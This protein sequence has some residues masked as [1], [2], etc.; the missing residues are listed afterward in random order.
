MPGI[1]I[2]HAARDK[3][4]A[5]AFVDNI[6]RLGSGA[7][8]EQVFYSSGPDTGVPTGSNLNE[9]LREKVTNVGLV[10]ALITPTFKDRPFCIAELSVAW[11]RVGSLFP[12]TMPGT[13]P[14]DLDG[15]LSGLLVRSMTD[16]AALDE[17]HDRICRE[18][19]AD[20]EAATWGHYK[21]TWL[22]SSK[23]LVKKIAKPTKTKS[24]P[25]RKSKPSKNEL[26]VHH[27]GQLFD[28]FVDAALYTADDTVG[29]EEIEKAIDRRTLIPSR[30]LYSSDSGADNWVRL[31]RDPM[32]RHH[33]ESVDYW[34]GNAGKKMAALIKDRLGREDFDYISLGS[35]DGEKDADLIATW[36]K[37]GSDLLYYPY[38]ISLPLVSRAIRTVVKKAPASAKKERLHIKSVLADFH[39]IGTVSEVFKHRNSPNVVALLGN[40]LGNLEHDLG[41]LRDLRG[42]LSVDDLLVLE[43]RLKSTEKKEKRLPELASS[44]SL[45]FDFGPLEYYFGLTFNEKKMSTTVDGEVSSFPNT[46]TT[47]VSCTGV[48]INGAPYE[49][50]KLMYIHEY[51]EED[52]LFKLEE[53]DFEIIERKPGDKGEDFLVCV[54]RKKPS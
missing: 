18:T 19:E 33:R 4:L 2:S 46:K 39:H 15:V 53:E 11:S 38:D 10:I 34:A 49:K 1:F 5:D 43:V 40:S 26:G 27:W 12:L 20:V 7:P 30:Y 28:S 41:F 44:Q 29:R 51:E 31:C 24:R 8:K 47:I 35:G 21:E 54:L 17:L 32:Y 48:K 36:L 42:Q 45:R 25:L 3:P 9:Y 50:A 52:F 23:S 13:K 37:S 22:T 16:E 14:D 6:V